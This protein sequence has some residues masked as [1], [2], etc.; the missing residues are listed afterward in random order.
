MSAFETITLFVSVL[1]AV[2]AAV[3][4]W[5][6]IRAVGRAEAANKIAEASLRY[7]VLVPALQDYRSPEMFIAIRSLWEFFE[8]DPLTLAQRFTDRRSMERKSLET[9][10]LEDRSIFTLS[11]I[12]FQR[13][14][15][16]HFYGLLTMMYDEGGFQRKWLYTYWSKSELKIIPEILIPLENALTQATGKPGLTDFIE[17]LRRLYDDSP[18]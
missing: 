9:L 17:R 15:V 2:A 12:D 18:S 7:D 8:E 10:P 5:Y 6:A 4:A 11:T 3:A 13:R 16:S 14:Q 1:S